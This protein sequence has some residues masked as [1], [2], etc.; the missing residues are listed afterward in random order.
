MARGD[1]VIQRIIRLIFDKA[2]ASRAQ[3][4]AEGSVSTM[5]RAFGKLKTAALAVGA[6]IGAAFAINKL[7]DFAAAS[8]R[9]AIESEKAWSRLGQALKV[10]GVQS[11]QTMQQARLAAAALQDMTRFGDEEAADA[12]STMVQITG[13]WE[14]AL[15]DLA[16]AADFASA[17]QI[18]LGAAAEIVARAR[19]GDTRLLKA[20]GIAI[21][22]GAAAIAE[23][24]RVSQGYAEV[25]GK[26]LAGQLAR[27]SN[28]WDEFKEAI[29]GAMIEAGEGTSI[30]Q[31]LINI[32][33]DLTTFIDR[34]KVSI[35]GWVEFWLG[36]LEKL[37]LDF[38]RTELNWLRMFRIAQQ[39]KTLG[40]RLGG[41]DSKKA[42]ADLAQQIEDQQA[43]IRRI[44]SGWEVSLPT[45]R[46]GAPDGKKTV[47]KRIEEDAR[48]ATA[49][50]KILSQEIE[51]L[52]VT[53]ASS[54]IT[55]ALATGGGFTPGSVLAGIGEDQ[56]A[57]TREVLEQLAEHATATFAG[58]T[59]NMDQ[60]SA[61]AY[62]A[63]FAMEDGFREAFSQ[64]A[65]DF[66]DMGEFA[67]NVLAAIAQGGIAAVQSLARS[68]MAEN[69]AHA[70]E[71][72]AL[73]IGSTFVNP[74]KAASHF[75]SA[76]KHGVAVAAWAA[77]A[78]AAGAAGGALAG[79]GG[80]SSG[81]GSSNATTNTFQGETRPG[82]INIHFIGKG[83]PAND[84]D[85]QTA[86]VLGHEM[87]KQALGG[88][89][90]VN[91]IRPS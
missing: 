61:A 87:G 62:S 75:A 74:A 83:W 77:L 85:F 60:L 47:P 72:V 51:G 11:E 54:P 22:D 90:R 69:V 10:A 40:G 26:T 73:G 16:I 59:F 7:K 68:K 18:E 56:A 66:E 39:I 21:K 6:A 58:I 81:G 36:D 23:M 42:L 15:Q 27:L 3:S 9:A 52:S 45:G 34:S 20:Y 86:V 13:N 65:T 49:A 14:Q 55:P 5:D 82:E 24:A 53:A 80:G 64:L 71:Q 31:T 88:N 32:L 38:A 19:N 46:L 89:V 78:G 25:E 91:I 76:A 37:R 50:V 30:I 28:G 12:L 29:G 1:N 43:L 33:K 48:S 8:L 84:R 17:K 41:E 57:R 79:G 2:A 67:G 44:E 63:A 35:R 70:I 4:Q